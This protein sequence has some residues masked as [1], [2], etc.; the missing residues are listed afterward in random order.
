[1]WPALS[2]SPDWYRRGVSPRYAPTDLDRHVAEPSRAHDLRQAER[3][4]AVRLIDLQAERCLGVAGIDTDDRQPALAQG[5]RQPIRQ[6][7]GLE[8]DAHR[9]WRTQPKHGGD[10]VRI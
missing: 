7:P 3:I 1:M 2:V 8:T 6:Q 4:I 10:T 9:V 5:A